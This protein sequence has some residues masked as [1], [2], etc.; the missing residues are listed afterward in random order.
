MHIHDSYFMRLFSTQLQHVAEHCLGGKVVGKNLQ[1]FNK[2]EASSMA[3]YTISNVLLTR[4]F[5]LSVLGTRP[6]ST[7][8]VPR[9]SK[10]TPPHQDGY[11]FRIKPQR[12]VT[13][14]VALDPADKINGCLHYVKGSASAPIRPHHPSGHPPF[15]TLRTPPPPPL[16]SHLLLHSHLIARCAWIFSVAEGVP[17][18]G[19]P[20][21]GH[22]E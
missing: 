7:I 11:Y 2:G 8:P 3:D 13:G 17:S 21:G 4:L 16:T 14:W 6:P 19:E 1:Y 22:P 5:S 15:T 18:T 9:F 12:A 20:G 10:P